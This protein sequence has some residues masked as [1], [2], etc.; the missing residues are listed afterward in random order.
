MRSSIILKLRSRD[1]N[2]TSQQ[3]K[4]WFNNRGRTDSSKSGRGDL[5]LDA[6]EKRKLAPVQAYCT[7]AW[8]SVLRPIVLARWAQEK[9]SEMFDDDEDPPEGEDTSSAESCIPLAF[10]IKIA[11]ELYEGLTD[12]EKDEIDRRREEDRKKMYL[13]VTEL[14]EEDRIAR[15]RVHK[16]YHPLTRYYSES[17]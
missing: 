10:K 2:M 15:L 17:I 16:K 6:N 8:D 3:I 7:Y 12:G 5:K 11:R 4:T 9:G 13:K 1:T 14:E